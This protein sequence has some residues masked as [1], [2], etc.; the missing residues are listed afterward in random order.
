MRKGLQK[1]GILM[2]TG[3]LV[4][5]GGASSSACPYH[6][7]LS[8]AIGRLET[9]SLMVA[10]EI[11]GYSFAAGSG[12]VVLIQINRL[13][14]FMDPRLDL[15]D[16]GGT[17]LMSSSLPGTGRAE[18]LSS[19][20]AASDSYCIL[21][22]DLDG[23]NQGSYNLSVQGVNCPAGAI[24]MEYNDSRQDSLSQFS[25]INAYQFEGRAGEVVSAEMIPF[26]G[27]I[28]PHLRM[29][30]PGGLKIGDDADIEFAL[31]SNIRLSKTGLHTLIATDQV[32]N[33]TG[34]Y[35]L[36]LLRSSTDL[37]DDADGLPDGFALEQNYPNPFNPQTS[38]KFTLPRQT[39]VT[40]DI[41]N[42]AGGLVRTLLS[43]D[44]S[45]GEHQI[46]WDGRDSD[47]GEMPSGIYFYRLRAGEF[48]A[49]KKM[50]LL[51]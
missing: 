34:N 51:R 25:Q 40:L 46:N 15:V 21:V 32:G 42:V 49:S 11:H 10:L 9:E 22:R 44:L 27:D 16:P 18:I 36:V 50:L 41:Y 45:A 38:I 47:G 30:D 4:F 48:S 5:T 13:W 3:M 43:R 17:V 20:L 24:M 39:F 28:Q 6:K 14:G 19:Q 7:C 37:T 2:L 29:F 8:T 35:F 31:L 1:L 23:E 26:T 33:R 12:D